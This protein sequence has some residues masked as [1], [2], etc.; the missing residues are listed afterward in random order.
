MRPSLNC[1]VVACWF[2][3]ASPVLAQVQAPA[4]VST[5][6]LPSI[7]TTT[8]DDFRRLP[9]SGTGTMLAIGGIAATAIHANDWHIT[10]GFS[11]AR[12]LNTVFEAG[13]AIG[14]ARAQLAGAI[15]TY[16]VGRFTGNR[17]VATLGADLIR[18]QVVTQTV[19]AAIKMSVKRMRPDGGEFSFPSGHSSVTF[20]TATVVQR[21]FGWK[22]GIPAYA[23]ASYVAA[24]RVHVKRHFLSDVA[25]GAALGI[26][27]GRT[28]TIG[29]GQTRFAVSPAVSPHQAGVSFTLVK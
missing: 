7:F 3:L 10:T 4:P 6:T 22:A 27:A 14:G 29:R 23:V 8:I 9:S 24:S 13:E 17:R 1:V 2:C 11:G 16:A 21:H 5:I 25:F 15:G 18:A 26:A 20:A 28:V 12:R 19:T